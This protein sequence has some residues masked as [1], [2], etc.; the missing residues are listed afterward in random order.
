MRGWR[1]GAAAW[2]P[3]AAVFAV[4][5]GAVSCA[6][7]PPPDVLE[8]VDS[9]R[10]ARASMVA[11]SHAPTAYAQAEKLRREAHDAFY[12]NDDLAGA[13]IIAERALAAYAE[14]VALARVVQAEG[15]RVALAADTATATQRLAE[16]DIEHQK[17]AADIAALQGRLR[18]LRDAEP[19]QPSEDA[20]GDRERA[21]AEVVT[22]L[23]LQARMLCAAGRLLAQSRGGAQPGE[24]K[25][26][27]A[28]LTKL[29][30]LLAEGPAAAP[31]DQATRCRAACLAG[32]T[33]VRRAHPDTKQATGAGDALLTALSKTGKGKPGRDDRGVVVTLRDL[34]QG[35]ALSSAGAAALKTVTDVAKQH[36][37]FPV[38]VVLHQG[39]GPLD[40]RAKTLWGERGKQVV[41]ELVKHLGK[42]RVGQAHLAGTSAPL[43]DPKGSHAARNERVE[44]VFVTPR[45]L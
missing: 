4:T 42:E 18:V 20:K 3:G 41:A 24:L 22:T 8:Q 30:Q 19:I 35:K 15:Q 26:A 14:A 28:K 21:R 10:K 6:P 5:L 44:L 39:R 27:L 29:E 1:P 9:V 32:L 40:A 7:I 17:V 31:I 36:P 25:D 37:T 34:F 33:Q 16:L 11:R 12:E 38:M 45:A 43:V 2:L 23:L 13:Q